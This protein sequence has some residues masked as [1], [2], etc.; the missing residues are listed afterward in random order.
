MAM[1]ATSHGPESFYVADGDLFAATPWTRG[2]W[3]PDCQHAGPPAALIGR[4]VE[5]C[6]GIGES[7]VDRHIGRITYE[8]L[9]PVPIAPLRV[10]VEVTRGGRRVDMVE[11]T[12]SVAEGGPVIRARAWRLLRREVELPPAVSSA[13]PASAAH[14]AGRPSG[15][16]GSPTPPDELERS[17]AFF[18]TGHE[19]GY[20]TA[21]DGRFERGSFVEIGPAVAWTRPLHPLV[22]G[23]P[24]TPL[25]RVLIAADSGNGISSTLDFSRYRFLN[26]DLTVHLARMPAGEW[27]CLDAV[28]AAEPHGAGI[29]DTMLLDERGPIGRAVQTLIIDER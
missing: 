18:P 10:E 27:V 14:R 1:D 4:A 12:L 21:M 25:Q 2:P 19:V 16:S 9:A 28:T 11:A 26:V 23:E 5:G 29:S 7:P 13:D 24:M 15:A 8:I 22:A 3:D 20:Q 6:P 17:E